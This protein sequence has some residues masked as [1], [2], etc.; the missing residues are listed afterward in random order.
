MDVQLEE[1]LSIVSDDNIK[2]KVISELKLLKEHHPTSYEHSLNVGSMYQLLMSDEYNDFEEQIFLGCLLHDIG[3]TEVRIEILDAPKQL[4][5]H[6]RGMIRNHAKENRNILNKI[7]GDQKRNYH[8]AYYIACGHH[9]NGNGSEGYPRK[10][11]FPVSINLREIYDGDLLIKINL[12]DAFD[13]MID[14]NRTYK[15]PLTPQTAIA[16]LK[17]ELPHYSS[18]LNKVLETHL[19]R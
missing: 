18:F 12:L 16:K 13:T 11:E 14:S 1:I 5:Y 6:E 2:K 3:K 7:F 4:H 15:Q 9:E 17:Q 8:L 10:S 19:Q